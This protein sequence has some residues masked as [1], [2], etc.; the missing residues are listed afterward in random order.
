MNFGV[1]LATPADVGELLNQARAFPIDRV[2]DNV[3]V[4]DDALDVGV[5][6]QEGVLA[7]VGAIHDVITI[8]SHP[9]PS[10][11]STVPFA[12]CNT[13]KTLERTIFLCV[14]VELLPLLLLH[15]SFLLSRT[16]S[17]SA[18]PEDVD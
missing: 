6:R 4:N 3:A 18:S 5:I 1:F 12:V 17:F 16:L 2:A 9:I 13:P 14:V 7:L 11:Y 8:P 10:A 15:A